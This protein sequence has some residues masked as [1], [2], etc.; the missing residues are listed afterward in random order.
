MSDLMFYISS[1]A[2]A[3]GPITLTA[4]SVAALYIIG[5]RDAFR[6]AEQALNNLDRALESDDELASQESPAQSID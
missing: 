1:I 4:L 5:P 3:L 6:S 2:S